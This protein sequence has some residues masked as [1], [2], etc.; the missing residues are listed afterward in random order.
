MPVAQS[1]GP[2]RPD[3]DAEPRPRQRP[4]GP[5]CRRST[6]SISAG[7]TFTPPRRM[8][9][10]R[11]SAMKRKPSASSRP[12]SPTVTRSPCREAAVLAGVVAVLELRPAA[13]SRCCPPR[14]Q[15]TGLHVV[16]EDLAP[17]RRPRRARRCPGA[18]PRPIESMVVPP[19]LGRG[20]VL[21]DDRP[22][23][24]DHRVFELGPG[25]GA[26]AWITHCSGD[27]S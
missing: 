7:Y 10:L 24:I 8:R 11:L 17:R 23:P 1:R 9:S 19:D 22:E 15:L 5:G 18:R 2:R 21:V 12:R 14:P 3:R 25:H 20:V 27:T 13:G 6:S 26:A 16:V 4:R